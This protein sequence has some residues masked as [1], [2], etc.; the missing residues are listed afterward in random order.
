MQVSRQGLRA[1]PGSGTSANEDEREPVMD[2]KAAGAP[3]LGK[4][5]PRHA[6]HNARGTAT[7]PYGKAP[8]KADLVARMKAAAE[9]RKDK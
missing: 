7:N 1:R 6:E 8:A 3:K 4:N 2:Y 5:A 9:K